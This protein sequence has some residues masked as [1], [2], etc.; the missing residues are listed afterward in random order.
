MISLEHR[1]IEFGS[2]VVR[3]ELS[4]C[5]PTH[6]VLPQL[7]NVIS[8]D[9]KESFQ[10]SIQPNERI[11]TIAA[12]LYQTSGAL[13]DAVKIKIQ[14]YEPESLLVVGGN[15]KSND[16]ISTCEALSIIKDSTELR[17]LATW[18]PNHPVMDLQTKEDA[19][20]TGVI[21]QPVLSS[22]GW[23]HLD[24]YFATPIPGFQMITGMAFPKS[25]KSLHFWSSLLEVAPEN[26]D[27]FDQSL[28]RMEN[29]DS[30][31]DW[32]KEQRDRLLEYDGIHGVHFMP[33][34]N[35][36]DLLQLFQK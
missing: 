19:G 18:D 22:I 23:Q 4:L 34:G 12:A 8:Q 25:A 13:R 35:T 16:S 5:Q 26:D 14:K 11:V 1:S 6:F 29:K 27:W 20:A 32:S 21:T 9:T 17:I 3:N 24:D 7:P 2:S 33:M 31:Q 10:T 36:A 28:N 30:R 15:T